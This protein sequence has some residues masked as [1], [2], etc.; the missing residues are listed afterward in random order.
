MTYDIYDENDCIILLT[1]NAV[2][3]LACNTVLESKNRH[4][5]VECNCSNRA[6]CDGGLDYVRFGAVNLDLVENLCEYKQYTRVEHE[7]LLEAEK[8]R[9]AV[10]LQKR[11]DNNEVVKIGGE[12]YSKSVIK[13]LVDNNEKYKQ[14]LET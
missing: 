4:N 7:A 12:W 2:K 5:F 11:I 13:L 9:K 1:R 14:L 6:F 8:D 3:C 10:M